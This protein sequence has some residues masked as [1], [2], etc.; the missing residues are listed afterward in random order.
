MGSFGETSCDFLTWNLVGISETP[1]IYMA[2]AMI[3]FMSRRGGGGY[4]NGT[5][6]FVQKRQKLYIALTGLKAFKHMGHV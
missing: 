1:L 4:I 5:D 3:I 6:V 2:S